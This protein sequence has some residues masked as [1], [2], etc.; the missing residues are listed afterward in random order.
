VVKKF[1]GGVLDEDLGQYPFTS[2][3]VNYEGS[4]VEIRTSK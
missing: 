4:E 2:M 3:I 1:R